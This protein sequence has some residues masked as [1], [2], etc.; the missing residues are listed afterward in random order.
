MHKSQSSWAQYIQAKFP[1]I[2]V[3]NQMTQQFSKSFWQL[4]ELALFTRNLE[5]F[6]SIGDIISVKFLV[7]ATLA[8]IGTV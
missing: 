2:L 5:I 1:E 8:V 7:L 4:L 3:Q 6:H